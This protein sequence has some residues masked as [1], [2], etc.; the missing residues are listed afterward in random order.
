MADKRQFITLTNLGTFAD[1]IK[2]KYALLGT[3]S[4]TSTTKSIEGTRKYAKEQADAVLGT[5]QDASSANTVYGAKALAESKVA[6]V[7]ATTN[8]GI[9]IGGTATNPTV[10]ID[11]KATDN[12]LAFDEDGKLFY[13]A[14][15][16]AEYTITKQ[17]SAD[18]G[19]IATYQL[20]KDSTAVGDKINIPKDFLVKGASIKTVA[21]ADQPYEGAKVGD[22]Y[23]DF[24]INVKSGSATTE[25]LYLPVQELV[26]A[27]V[28]DNQ[29]I[30]L[31]ANNTFSLKI[32]TGSA[33][34]VSNDGL[35][36][37]EASQSAKGTMS[38]ADKTKLDGISAEANKVAVD[39]NG[40][41]T[42][43]I[44]GTAVTFYDIDADVEAVTAQQVQALLA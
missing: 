32:K 7:T 15:T 44:D 9:A 18:E 6:S 35:D 31:G 25:H 37:A 14:A 13:K 34:S 3:A 28:G 26:D 16:A 12:D 4:D 2:S 1:E 41:G 8:K 30:V 21:T 36:I 22:K 19:F 40:V 29:G 42:G 5:A 17:A 33:L 24:E 11:L 23:I 20:F 27:Y 43:S 10:G 39:A 38:A